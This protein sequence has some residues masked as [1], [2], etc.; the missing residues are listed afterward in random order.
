MKAKEYYKTYNPGS[1]ITEIK[2]EFF[3]SLNDCKSILEFGCNDG[4]NL[5]EIKEQYPKIEILGIEINYGAVLKA[6]RE[7]RSYVLYGDESLLTRISS[8][9][10]DIVFTSSVLCHIE[11]IGEIVQDLQRIT[12]KRTVFLETNEVKGQFYF[13]HDYEALGYKKIISL[14]NP[15]NPIGNGAVYDWWEKTKR[16]DNS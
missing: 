14:R 15:E 9:S 10:R 1:I 12:K 8:Q 4:T 16:N 2:K 3:S 7:H 13:P 5:K 6:H 11:K